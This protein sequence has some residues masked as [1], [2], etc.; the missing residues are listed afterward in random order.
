MGK[1]T[2]G[3]TE[4]GTNVNWP[5]TIIAIVAIGISIISLIESNNNSV[6][7]R[8]VNVYTKAI[9]SI[10]TIAF[11]EW[12]EENGYGE[13]FNVDVDDTWINNQISKAVEINAELEMYDEENAKRYWEIVSQVF[14]EEHHF[15]GKKY[16]EFRDIIR[17]EIN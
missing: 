12:S 3:I 2:K 10:E 15:D 1:T 6:T 13:V 9:V 17:E 5:S 11:H 16:E 7:D 4:K 8:R 14:G